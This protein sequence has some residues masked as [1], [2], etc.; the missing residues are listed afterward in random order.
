[1][2]FSKTRLILAIIIG[3]LLSQQI[4]SVVYSVLME[5]ADP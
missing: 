1:M 4:V 3:L 5:T 2:F